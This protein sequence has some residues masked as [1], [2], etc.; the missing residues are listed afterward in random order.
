GIIEN[1]QDLKELLEKKGYHF[2][3]DTDTEVLTALVDSF[4]QDDVSLLDA[5]LDA[6]KV[7]VGA[8]GIAVLAHDQPS[9]II[10]ARSGSP[11]II[12]LG[13]DETFI[14]SDAAALLGHTD[15]VIYV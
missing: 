13:S 14:A 9:H 2:K 6:L 15:Q 4:Y 8:Y 5:V 3:S 10:A 11:L 12:G 7:V 1:F